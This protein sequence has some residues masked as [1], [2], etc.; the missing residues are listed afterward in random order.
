MKLL[1]IRDYNSENYNRSYMKEKNIDGWI[2]VKEKL[3]FGASQPYI[4][5]GG[6]WWCGFGENVGVEI[7]KEVIAD[8]LG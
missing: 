2:K 6:I 8:F 5:E 4:K 7:N 1:V 3:H